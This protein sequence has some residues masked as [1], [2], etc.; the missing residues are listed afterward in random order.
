MRCSF[1]RF[2]AVVLLAGLVLG[3]GSTPT[4]QREVTEPLPTPGRQGTG[5]TSYELPERNR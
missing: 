5:G 3:C 2:L 4:T 1:Y